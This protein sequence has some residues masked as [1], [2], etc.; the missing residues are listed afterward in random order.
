MTREEL[1]AKRRT[2]YEAD[3]ADAE[4]LR[5]EVRKKRKAD[6]DALKQGQ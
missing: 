4:T 1:K 6:N 5:G 2:I 3:L